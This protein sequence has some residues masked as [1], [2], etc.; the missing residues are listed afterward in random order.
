MGIMKNIIKQKLD[1]KTHVGDLM[2]TPMNQ[3][4]QIARDYIKYLSSKYGFCGE[5]AVTAFYHYCQ[6]ILKL[7]TQDNLYKIDKE[8]REWFKNY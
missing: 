2:L 1:I 4:P 5:I 6:A 3:T 8:G 7:K